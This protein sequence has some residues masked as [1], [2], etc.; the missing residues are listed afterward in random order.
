MKRRI[1]LALFYI[2]IP[3]AMVAGLIYGLWTGKIRAPWK[4]LPP[5]NGG[6]KAA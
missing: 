1:I 4:R 3:G 5:D 6:G 2:L